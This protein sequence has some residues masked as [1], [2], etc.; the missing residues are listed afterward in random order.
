MI[1]ETKRLRIRKLQKKD[2]DLFFEMMSNP[3]VMLPIPQKP[4]TRLESD[5]KFNDLFTSS[6]PK[7]KN[8]WAAAK[9]EN[10]EFIGI[11]GFLINNEQDDEI[12]YRLLENNWGFGF[13]TEIAEGLID[14]G[15][16]ILK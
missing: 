1:F 11:C 7:T 5:Q 15:F 4:M 6:N 14:Y 10:N 9:K 16:K 8:I 13:G 2:K 3:N 12:A